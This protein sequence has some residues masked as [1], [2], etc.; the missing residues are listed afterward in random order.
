MGEEKE[1]DCVWVT[2]WVKRKDTSK[3]VGEIET[4]RG[5]IRTYVIPSVKRVKGRR[6]DESLFLSVQNTKFLK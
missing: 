2:E 5:V 1:E 4:R 3:V 6:G